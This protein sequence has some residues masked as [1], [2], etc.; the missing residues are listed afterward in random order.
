MHTHWGCLC[1]VAV[2]AYWSDRDAH[3]MAITVWVLDCLG[4]RVAADASVSTLA[5]ATRSS[6]EAPQ[7]GAGGG[8]GER[9]SPRAVLRGNGTRHPGGRRD[10]VCR[11]RLEVSQNVKPWSAWKRLPSAICAP[12][13]AP[14]APWSGRWPT[15]GELISFGYSSP[16][17]RARRLGKHVG[18]DYYYCFG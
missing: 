13:S 10:R 9:S 5:S 17:S 7:R 15:S 3:L 14:V 18:D 11:R 12:P 6:E 16:A 2:V 1:G 4:V 8:C